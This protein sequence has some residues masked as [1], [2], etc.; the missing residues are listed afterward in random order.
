M[1]S[2]RLAKVL[3]LGTEPGAVV[4]ERPADARAWTRGFVLGVLVGLLLAM[5]TWCVV[6]WRL[7]GR[8]HEKPYLHDGR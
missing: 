5:A 8:L 6:L 4:D 3:R 1:R 7:E 2:G